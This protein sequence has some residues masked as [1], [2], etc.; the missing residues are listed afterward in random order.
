MEFRVKINNEILKN[1]PNGLDKFNKEFLLDDKLYGIY[2][3]FSYDLTF[4]GDGY[5]KIRDFFYKDED[6]D[7]SIIVE[8]YCNN[9]WVVVFDGISKINSIKIFESEKQATLEIEDRSPLS[10]ITK[11]SEIIVDLQTTKDIFGNSITPATFE[12]ISLDGIR[13]GTASSTYQI[14]WY[15]AMRVVLE[16]ITGTK[17]N[18]S[19]NFLNSYSQNEIWEV[20]FFGTMADIINITINF[21]N[22]QG[23]TIQLNTG[24][25]IGY[26]NI[27]VLT[28]VCLNEMSG[29]LTSEVVSSLE[30]WVDYRAFLK[31]NIDPLNPNKVIFENNLPIK[32]NSIDVESTTPITTTIINT[33]NYVDGG[34]SPTI[35]SYRG[36]YGFNIPLLNL[37]FKQMMQELNKVYN[38]YF[39]AKY[40]NIDEIDIEILPYSDVL[41]NS[42]DIILDST[43]DVEVELDDTNLYTS[44]DSSDGSKI[45]LS[46]SKRSFVSQDCVNSSTLDLQND[47]IMGQ[48]PTQSIPQEAYDN[49]RIDEVFLIDNDGLATL[50]GFCYLTP[51]ASTIVGN[52]PA[53]RL[54]NL[55]NTNWNKIYRHLPLIKRNVNGIASF[56]SSFF[57]GDYNINITN[58]TNG[59]FKKYQFTSTIKNVKFLSL[60]ENSLNKAKFNINN[61][62]RIGLIKRIDYNYNTGEAQFTILGE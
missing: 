31:I 6:C 12:T 42:E 51:F 40:N 38:V 17:V 15:E 23:N 33:Q 10:L 21:T 24:S 59:Y 19:S 11:N 32:I 58:N 4:V 18:I 27:N 22:F 9:S 39:T 29:T 45:T 2:T 41:Y 7:I 44:I 60:S 50:T 16:S 1:N 35:C 54:I 53:V 28:R 52:V 49:E 55:Y 62:Y 26:N 5:C 3:V 25:A 57:G 46:Q 61:T 56:N 13:S 8:Q 14:Y 48:I 30:D 36:L 43:K 20:E 37:S 34:N 47:F